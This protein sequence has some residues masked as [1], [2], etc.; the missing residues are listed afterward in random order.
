MSTPYDLPTDLSKVKK[1]EWDDKYDFPRDL[2]GYGENSF[3]P[4]WPNGAKIAVSFVINYEEGAEHTVLNGDMHSETHLWEAPGGAPKIEERAV[5]IESEY[6]YGSRTGVWRLFR[7]FNK[8]NYKYTLYAVGKAIED[9]PAVGI[10]SVKNGH[11]VASHAYRWIDYANMPPE[12]E[13]AYIKK[14]IE[15]IAKICGEPPKGWYYGRLSSR[16]QALVWEVYKEMGV[17]LLWDSD[18][19][20]DDLPYWVDVPA[21][22]NDADPK[23]MLMIPYSYGWCPLI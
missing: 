11:D 2:V 20:A 23:G 6:D 21:E 7:L 12:K 16:S 1:F 5:N 14:E 3:N 15:T 8:F 10:S 9:N 22:K 13:K 4:Q 17:P 19:Y 18:S